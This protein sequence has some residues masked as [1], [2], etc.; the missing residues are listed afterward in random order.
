M[1]R[2]A[3]LIAVIA[4]ALAAA[5]QPTQAEPAK[6]V[7][8]VV[9][10]GDGVAKHFRFAWKEDMTVQDAIDLAQ[11][12]PH[13]LKY[14]STGSGATAF[15]TQIDDVRNEGAG[16]DKKNWQFWINGQ[17]AERGFGVFKLARGDKVLWKFA[18]FEDD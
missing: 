4:L 12:N 2:P 7:S 3:I 9:D 15:L 10:Y 13:G 1:Y 5:A 6:N 14:R 18:V 16:A 8:L 11:A 17:R